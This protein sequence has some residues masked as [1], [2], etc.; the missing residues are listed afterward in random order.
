[1]SDQ[2]PALIAQEILYRYP[3]PWDDPPPTH[4]EQVRTT[5]RSVAQDTW[6]EFSHRK[7]VLVGLTLIAGLL[8]FA[9]LGPYWTGHS[10]S[11]QNL[12]HSNL[13]PVLSTTRM[14]LPDGSRHNF[15]ITDNLKV[16]EISDKGAIGQPLTTVHDDPSHKQTTFG[17]TMSDGSSFTMVLSYA[18]KPPALLNSEGQPLSRDHKIWNSDYLLGTN[19]LGQ[20]LLTRLMY[21]TRISLA[22]A[23]LAAAINLTIGV[24][25]GAVSGYLGGRADAIMMRVVDVIDTIPLTLY[26]IL[27]MVYLGTGL[28]AIVLALSSVYWVSMARIVRGEMH[29]I[30]QQEFVIAAR[31]IGSSTRTIL[32]RHMIPGA[33]GSIV[34]TATMLIP[35]AIFI[36]AFLG[37]I[38]LGVQSPAASLGTMCNDALAT[39]RTAP[40][41]LVLPA[42]MICLAMFAFTFVGD[43]LRDAMDPRMRRRR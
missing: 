34:V 43:G 5:S 23:F 15:L 10:Q 18:V 13:A 40:Y 4:A 42:L 31:T 12:V 41:Q 17:Y 8:V 1:M 39:L 16:L 20:D 37:F 33:M 28:S 25:Y 14:A 6:R 2:D 38:G 3:A 11:E 29:S 21:G 26:V 19:A 9:F 24:A 22:V 7:S 32:L 35:T 27:I 36:E 30:K